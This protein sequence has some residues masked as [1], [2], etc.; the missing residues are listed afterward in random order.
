MRCIFS[1][2]AEDVSLIP[3][4]SFTD[5]LQKAVMDSGLYEHFV[6]DLWLAHEQRHGFRCLGP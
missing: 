4:N 2:F 6:R 5:I 3:A 1:M